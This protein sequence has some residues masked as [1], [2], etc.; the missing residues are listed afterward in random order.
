M[1][2]PHNTCMTTAVVKLKDRS[3]GALCLSFAFEPVGGR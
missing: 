2:C 1:T 3:S